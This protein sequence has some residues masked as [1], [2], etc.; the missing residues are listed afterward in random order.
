MGEFLKGGALSVARLIEERAP[1]IARNFISWEETMVNFSF[2][3]WFNV[4]KETKLEIAL[5][6]KLPRDSF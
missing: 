2:K 3:H 4:K 5:T 1:P 6:L